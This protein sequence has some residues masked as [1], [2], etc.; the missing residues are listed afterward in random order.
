MAEKK[1]DSGLTRKAY[2]SAVA[3]SLPPRCGL[4]YKRRSK[5]EQGKVCN[6]RTDKGKE[7]HGKA[8]KGKARQRKARKGKERQRKARKGKERQGETRNG[9]G[10]WRKE[11]NKRHDLWIDKE[12]MQVRGGE[13]FATAPQPAL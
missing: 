5:A 8:R 6:A 9:K 7:R 4:K 11:K 1:K 13:K 12:R 3:K 2:E 10:G